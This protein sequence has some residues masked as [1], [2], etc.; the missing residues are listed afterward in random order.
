MKNTLVILG[1]VTLLSACQTNSNYRNSSVVDYLYPE[2]KNQQVS[3][4]IPILTLPLKIGIAFT[5]SGF[6][7]RDALHEV[8]K[9]EL[10]NSISDH[11]NTYEFV[12]S[13]TVI[14]SDYL[15]PQ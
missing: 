2:S 13:I 15:R 8:K 3:Q 1:L 5:P 10:M 14:P 12:E 9:I 7:A 4:E 6:N 11:F